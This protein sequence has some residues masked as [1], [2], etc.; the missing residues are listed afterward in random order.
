M[1]TNGI[2]IGYQM[3]IVSA[4]YKLA[5]S[6]DTFPLLQSPLI[7]TTFQFSSDSNSADLSLLHPFSHYEFTLQARTSKG[8]GSVVWLAVETQPSG[9]S[10]IASVHV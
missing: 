1:N 6:G 5:E 4:A 8:L 10:K 3:T 7:N 9:Q 2:L